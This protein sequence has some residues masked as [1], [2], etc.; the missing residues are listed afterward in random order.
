LQR[1][2]LASEVLS[3][4]AY[5]GAV[6]GIVAFAAF[7]PNKEEW[8]FGAVLCGAALTAWASLKAL[9]FLE[10]DGEADTALCFV[11]SVFFG[12]GLVVASVVQSS[13]PAW[14]RQMQGLLFGQAATLTDLHVWIYGG[15]AVL[16]CGFIAL[17][18]Y[19]LQAMLYSRDYASQSQ[20]THL[21]LGKNRVLAL[22]V[23]DHRRNSER[24]CRLDGRPF[25]RSG[26]GGEWSHRLST[27]FFWQVFLEENG[28]FGNV[29]AQE[30]AL[31]TGP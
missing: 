2:S 28:W 3:H 7:F 12:A 30:G 15:I 18:F 11:L 23:D 20:H 31:P 10:H 22:D 4:S 27:N 9:H 8:A 14:Y 25:D 21:S 17:V 19:P 6:F 13:F 24:R 29:L 26:C 1:R 5:P 16:T